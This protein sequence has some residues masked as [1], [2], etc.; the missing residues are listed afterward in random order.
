MI[1]IK[2]TKKSKNATISTVLADYSNKIKKIKKE[3]L[4]LQTLNRKKIDERKIND[5]RKTI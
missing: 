3:F 1:T 5:I 2:N 4:S